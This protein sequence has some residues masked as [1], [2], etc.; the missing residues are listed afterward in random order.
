MTE[1]EFWAS[2]PRFFDAKVTAYDNRLKYEFERTRV[3]SFLIC[4]P[5]LKKNATL[6]R[7]WPSPW[8]RVKVVE[9]HPIDPAILANFEAHANVELE[10]MRNR[11]NGN[12]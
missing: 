2:T 11:N 12:N 6:E 3:S 4:S 5:H 10:Q 9:W 1:A 8:H 7:F